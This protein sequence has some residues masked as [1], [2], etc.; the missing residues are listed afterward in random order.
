MKI[1]SERSLNRSLFL[2]E[3][4]RGKESSFPMSKF[5]IENNPEKL[6]ENQLPIEVIQFS[7]FWNSDCFKFMDFIADFTLRKIYGNKNGG[8]IP[9]N[10]YEKT[11]IKNN[12]IFIQQIIT[13]KALLSNRFFEFSDSWVLENYG[14][15]FGSITNSEFFN[16]LDQTSKCKF[17]LIYDYRYHEEKSLKYHYNKYQSNFESFFD[18]QILDKKV[19]KNEKVYE[20]LYKLSFN[21]ILGNLFI[22]NL[23]MINYDWID[24]KK[25][26]ELSKFEQMFYRFYILSKPK[27]IKIFYINYFNFK[28]KIGSLSKDKYSIKSILKQTLEGL[29]DKKM[30]NDYKI[31]KYSYEVGCF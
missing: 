1:V 11:S 23:S 14:N 18:Y 13:N 15:I 21:S 28:E 30:I 20:R 6:K 17:K 7:D 4:V 31:T 2:V 26:L 19:G 8:T 24:Y 12:E 16:I 5:Q 9:K 10:P 22:S 25:Y 29:K 27:K 3:K